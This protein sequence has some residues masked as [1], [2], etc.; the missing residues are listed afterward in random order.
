MRKIGTPPW[1]ITAVQV[2]PESY[3][4]Q[5]PDLFQLYRTKEG[6]TK[7][8]TSGLESPWTMKSAFWIKTL[9]PGQTSS[10]VARA[11]KN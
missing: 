8:Q 6:I 10:L 4:Y 9:I 3:H 7:A 5:E 2:Y 1:R 11:P